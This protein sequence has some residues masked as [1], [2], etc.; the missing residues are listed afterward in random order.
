M[1]ALQRMFDS[2]V[3]T[4]GLYDHTDDTY[5]TALMVGSYNLA[6]GITTND[7]ISYMYHN[8][9]SCG[10]GISAPL[11][12]GSKDAFLT[13]CEDCGFTIATLTQHREQLNIKNYDGL[14]ITDEESFKKALYLSSTIF[15]VR[16]YWALDRYLTSNWDRHKRSFFDFIDPELSI[17][18]YRNPASFDKINDA[19]QDRSSKINVGDKVDYDLSKETLLSPKNFDTYFNHVKLG[20]INIFDNHESGFVDK[21]MFVTTTVIPIFLPLALFAPEFLKKVE[22]IKGYKLRLTDEGK[23]KK[24]K[25]IPGINVAETISLTVESFEDFPTDLKCLGCGTLVDGEDASNGK[26]PHCL[27]KLKVTEKVK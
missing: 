25:S 17:S 8:C 10:C 11:A 14:I 5:H 20:N 15:I 9:P 4:V 19:L 18:M 2:S 3:G 27:K 21:M 23:D 7:K 6:G 26:C 1:K 16:T 22:K 24:L 12:T 13:E